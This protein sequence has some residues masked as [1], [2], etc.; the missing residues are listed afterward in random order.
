MPLLDI[1]NLSAG[2]G[3]KTI[4]D[5]LSLSAE[6][7]DVV[8]LIGPSGSGKS[9]LLRVLIGLTP[10]SAGTVNIGGDAINYAD[11]AG[12][13]AL[14]RRMSI[15]FQ[16]FNLF[17][18]MSVLDNLTLAPVRTLG[19]ARAEAEARARDLL[20]NVGLADKAGSYPDQLSGGQQ[21]RVAIA[22]AL[23][24]QPEILLLDEVTSA[25]DPER[26]G[27]VLETIRSLASTGITM[28]LVSH[29]MAFVREISTNVVMMDEGRVVEQGSPSAIFETPTQARTKSFMQAIIRH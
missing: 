11:K 28:L 22:R 21:Q 10:P 2:Y 27:E 5:G 15:V 17:Q 18:N 19:V 8:S 9:T 23:A 24:M 3:S 13:K 29:E 20:A 4:L 25:L 16:Q 7:G 14:R 1:D 12:L 26:V 6:R